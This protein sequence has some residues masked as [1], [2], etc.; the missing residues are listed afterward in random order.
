MECF[1]KRIKG[2][3]VA[4][5]HR[6]GHIGGPHAAY[7]KSA[8]ACSL[9]GNF[10]SCHVDPLDIILKA[11]IFERYGIRIKGVGFYDIRS[12]VDIGAMNASDFVGL[13]DTQQVI[14]P[15]E[16]R[17]PSGEFFSPKIGLVQLKSLDHCAHC[18]VKH[19]HPAL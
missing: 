13:C 6:Q 11:I 8:V 4:G 14:A 19:E 7:H 10:G 18:S 17:V 5:G 15:F 16:C 12:C 1:G 2:F 3:I 9:T